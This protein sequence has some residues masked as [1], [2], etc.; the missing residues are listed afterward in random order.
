VLIQGETGTGKNVVARLLHRYSFRGE[1]AFI[2]VNCPA[3]PPSLIESELFGHVKGAFTDA[4][5][6]RPGLFRLAD[7]G[8]LVLDEI[9]AI[10]PE[11][12]AKLLQAIEEKRFIPVGGSSAVEVHTRIVS[13]TN[14]D[15]R[16]MMRS[17]EFRPDLYHRIN[18]A[19]L[20]LP[21]LRDRP[22][23]IPLLVEHFLC[24]FAR[25]FGKEYEPVDAATM[26]LLQSYP[27]PGNV[28]EL[29]NCL[30]YGVLTGSFSPPEKDD[31]WREPSAGETQPPPAPEGAVA[32]LK[33]ARER[34]VE[35]AERATV[36]KALQA[37]E[38]NR[39]RAAKRLGISRRTLLRK[40][41]Q[42]DI[43]T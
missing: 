13:I 31:S 35:R 32:T 16:E 34:A 38:Q 2:R 41:R 29:S 40:I 33:E 42:Y 20:Y 12:Q 30:K 39:T 25:Q 28:R 5:T 27:W 22:G 7:G 4:R 3:I 23:D 11:L 9:S 37:E 26:E 19:P 21:P 18:E 36:L 24:R 6:S 43:Q 1:C 17:N 10:P 14:Q 8:T 15:V